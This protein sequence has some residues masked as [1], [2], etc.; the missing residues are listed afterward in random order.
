MMLEKRIRPYFENLSMDN[1]NLLA[2]LSLKNFEKIMGQLKLI[3]FK[4]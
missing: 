3:G 4:N 1:Y 2:N